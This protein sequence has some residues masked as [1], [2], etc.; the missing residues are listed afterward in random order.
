MLT[1]SDDCAI[2][3]IR[4][5]TTMTSSPF[6]KLIDLHS[7]ACSDEGYSIAVEMSALFLI[8]TLAA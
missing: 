4:A 3:F 8:Q 1:Y 5:H 7:S 2:A 6:T